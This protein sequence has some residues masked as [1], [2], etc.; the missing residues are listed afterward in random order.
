M[1][2]DNRPHQKQRNGNVSALSGLDPRASHNTKQVDNNG[3]QT[4]GEILSDGLHIPKNDVGSH[5]IDE[6]CENACFFRQA[7]L[8]SQFFRNQVNKS[9][10]NQTEQ[11]RQ[12]QIQVERI[13]ARNPTEENTEGMEERPPRVPCEFT[14]ARYFL[15][16]HI[17]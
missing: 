7:Q 14:L 1:G 3:K 15:R 4:H 17:R 13:D 9:E 11:G 2:C 5:H 10:R 12:N 6:Q 16:E 8:P